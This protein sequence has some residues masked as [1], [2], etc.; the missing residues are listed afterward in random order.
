MVQPAA[1]TLQAGR[2]AKVQHIHHLFKLQGKAIIDDKDEE[3]GECTE[4]KTVQCI[5]EGDN[6][7]VMATLLLKPKQSLRF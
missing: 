6:Q 1:N 7:A 4:C 3:I 2:C 5:S